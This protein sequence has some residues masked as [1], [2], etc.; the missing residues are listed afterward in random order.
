LSVTALFGALLMM[1][2]PAAQ[3]APPGFTYSST[4]V[5]TF[6][7]DAPATSTSTLD[8]TEYAAR[9]IMDVDV[10][11]AMEH[12]FL[13]DLDPVTLTSPLGTEVELW[14]D[15]CTSEVMDPSDPFTLD[16]EAS[17]PMGT[18]CPPTGTYFPSGSLSDF[19]GE[20]Y[21]GT[22]TLSFTDTAAVDTGTLWAW[23][24][25]IFDGCT[26]HAAGP[27]QT[28]V[29]TDGNDVICGGPGPDEMLGGRGG[30]L[31]LGADGD[32]ILYGQAGGDVIRGGGGRDYIV[33]GGGHDSLF[34][35][36]ANDN[37]R[38]KDQLQDTVNGGQGLDQCQVDP[39]DIV[40]NCNP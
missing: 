30:D 39:Q 35:D 1:P 31:I 15:E 4:D 21:Q 37:I 2:G 40:S 32:D 29:G 7:A 11:I 26:I 3:A 34:G 24:L 10:T 17:D 16:D 12:S 36:K 6:L 33:G 13:G 9:P 28:T 27:N 22:W 14:G 5:P 25:R 19:D 38:A 8:I 18:D 23:S 20:N